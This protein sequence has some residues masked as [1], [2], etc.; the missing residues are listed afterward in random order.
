[1]L[2]FKSFLENVAVYS[3]ENPPPVA[4]YFPMEVDLFFGTKQKLFKAKYSL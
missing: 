2:L 1:M 3:L 4:N